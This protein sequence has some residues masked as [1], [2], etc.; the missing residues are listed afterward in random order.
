MLLIATTTESPLISLIVEPLDLSLSSETSL[1][2]KNNDTLP[3]L[4]SNHLSQP[5]TMN[6]S[7][8][9]T[10][11][12]VWSSHFVWS[13]T[14]MVM[15]MRY[16]GDRYKLIPGMTQTGC[17]KTYLNTLSENMEDPDAILSCCDFSET[18]LPILCSKNPP[19]LLKRLIR[20]PDA[21]LIPLVPILLRGLW[22]FYQ[23]YFSS[24]ER[25][26]ESW[27]TYLARFNFYM[28]LLIFRGFVLFMGLNA[29]EQ[30]LVKLPS[31]TCWFSAYTRH[32][33]C[34][35]LAFDFSDHTVLYLGQILPLPLTE[36]LFWWS[37]GKQQRPAEWK[38]L[39]LLVTLWLFYL[40]Y[41]TLH[42]GEWQTAAYFHTSGEVWIGYFISLWLQVPLAYLSCVDSRWRTRFF[43]PWEQEE[44]WNDK[45][46]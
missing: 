43:G 33:T 9:G 24:S 17:F 2:N 36:V 34:R 14:V 23:I 44:R 29:L 28:L 37:G 31:E 38:L 27:K 8:L 15:G 11:R 39:R 41:I 19:P 21:W 4:P 22:L 6:D 3:L 16:N 30:S 13:L 25:Q 45:Q 18:L 5:C 10:N 42:H 7:Q 1:V 46:P 26:V 32:Q 40:Y 20:L 12:I 35:G